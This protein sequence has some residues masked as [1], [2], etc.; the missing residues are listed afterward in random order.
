MGTSKHFDSSAAFY[1]KFPDGI[2][3]LWRGNFK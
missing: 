1:L 3:R 2:R